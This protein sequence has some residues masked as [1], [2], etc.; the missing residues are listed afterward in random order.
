MSS[1]LQHSTFPEPLSSI[2]LVAEL[3]KGLEY[4]RPSSARVS[5]DRWEDR[6]IGDIGCDRRQT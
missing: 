1:G 2:E 4:L 3:L 5:P 6:M